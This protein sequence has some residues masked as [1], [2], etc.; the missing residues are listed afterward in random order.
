MPFESRQNVHSPHCSQRSHAMHP[1]LA[2]SLRAVVRSLRRAA[3]K[4]T[5]VNRRSAAA[6]WALSLP[7]L[8][9]AVKGSRFVGLDWALWP[10]VRHGGTSMFGSHSPLVSIALFATTVWLAPSVAQASPKPQGEHSR[11]ARVVRPR[12]C[13][14]RAV[15]VVAGKE[16]ATVALARCDGSASPEG[17]D[18]VSLLVRPS[19]IARPKESLATL[20][21]VRGP[22]LA[23]GIRR[24][25]PRLVERLELVADH[26]HKSGQSPR[27]LLAPVA[28]SSQSTGGRRGTT[29]SLDFRMESVTGEALA[30]FCKTLPDATCESSPHGTFVRL[31]L[32]G[33][34]VAHVADADPL[35]PTPERST[36]TPLMMPAQS[37]GKLAPLPAMSRPAAGSLN[38]SDSR[39]FL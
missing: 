13:S 26:F 37:G 10:N 9:R 27:I 18:Q 20:S 21:K 32:R 35:A 19:G 16:S 11:V 2:L 30:S 5:A 17:V 8:P 4:S 34:G 22:E 25:D 15:E 14:K 7:S 6:I 3:S 31:E 36:A 23:P 24:V 39:R 33:S 12:P 29:H 1:M 38:T 28:P